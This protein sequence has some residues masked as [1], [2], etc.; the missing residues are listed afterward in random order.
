MTG[1]SHQ[2]WGLSASLEAVRH[3]RGKEK[4]FWCHRRVISGSQAE[5]HGGGC[6]V[7]KG[8]GAAPISEEVEEAQPGPG[9]A[10]RWQADAAGLV[11]K[12]LIHVIKDFWSFGRL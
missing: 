7:C 3:H 10:R 8:P 4:D 5:C 11:G 1:L 2:C 12:D 9:G 6:L